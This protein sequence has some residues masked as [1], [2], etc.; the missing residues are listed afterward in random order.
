MF[1]DEHE[2]MARRLIADM[3]GARLK[4]VTAESCTGGLIAGLLT[5]V[6]GSSEVLE[7]GF[8][9]YSNAAKIS[10]LGVPRTTIESVGAV[11]AEVA[12]AMA[13]GALKASQA[14]ISVSVTGIAG[15]GGGS[16][17]KPIGLVYLA[18]LR[19]GRRVTGREYRFGDIGRSTIRLATVFEALALIR[20][21]M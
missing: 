6:P 7:R 20:D 4:L 10:D 3:W 14:D 12:A 2:E 15:P 9:T 11:S 8:V 19:K 16:T 13:Q 17:F 1:P 21:V 5:E 18:A